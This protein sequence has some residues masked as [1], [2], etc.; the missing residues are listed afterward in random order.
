MKLGEE[1]AQGIKDVYQVPPGD[2]G[3]P[4]LLAW[5]TFHCHSLL[6]CFNHYQPAKEDQPC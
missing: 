4:H 3:S 1:Q 6:A 2:P 5:I